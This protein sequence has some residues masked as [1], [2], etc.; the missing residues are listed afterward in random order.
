MT[1]DPPRCGSPAGL[2]A[3]LEEPPRQRANT[4]GTRWTGSARRWPISTYWPGSSS[5]GPSGSWALKGGQALLARLPTQARSRVLVIP[6]ALRKTC[7]ATFALRTT[8]WPP[9]LLPPRTSGAA[10]WDS[11]VSDDDSPWTNLTAANDALAAFREL[12][13][14]DAATAHSLATLILGGF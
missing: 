11:Y 12:V 6:V 1:N 5:R 2:R 14:A 13:L 7:R 3:A 9:A 8:V 10:T 4:T